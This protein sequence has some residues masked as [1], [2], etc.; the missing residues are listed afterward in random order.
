[1]LMIGKVS[2]PHTCLIFHSCHKSVSSYGGGGPDSLFSDQL[3]SHK[4]IGVVF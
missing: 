3:Y 4:I 1:M 2:G